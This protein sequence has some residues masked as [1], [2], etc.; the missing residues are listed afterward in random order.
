M[1]RFIED[2]LEVRP[3]KDGLTKIEL[4]PSNWTSDFPGWKGTEDDEGIAVSHAQW[5]SV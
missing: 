4:K 1:R 3:L 5:R 2:G